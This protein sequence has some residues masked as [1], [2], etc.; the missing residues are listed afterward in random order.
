MAAMNF[1]KIA[2]FHSLNA[3][4]N[5]VHGH[6]PTHGDDSSRNGGVITFL[7]EIANESPVYLELIKR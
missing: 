3:L 4:G 6:F 2:L 7:G 1:E 5:H